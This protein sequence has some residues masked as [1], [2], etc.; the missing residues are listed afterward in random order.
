MLEE[1]YIEDNLGDPGLKKK[2]ED[3]YFLKDEM[4]EGKENISRYIEIHYI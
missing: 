3:L 1:E 2:L 4:T